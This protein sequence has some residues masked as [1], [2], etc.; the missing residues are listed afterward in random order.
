[1]RTRLLLLAAALLALLG[2][3][4][5]LVLARHDEGGPGGGERAGSGPDGPA[6]REPGLATLPA[7]K[8]THPT[9]RGRNLPRVIPCYLLTAGELRRVLDAPMA[10]LGQRAAGSSGFGLTG[11]QREDCHWFS[12]L[13]DGPYVVLSTVTTTQLR[14]RGE[15]LTARKY[16]DTV[17]DG[18]RTYLR[19]IGDA[20][21]AYGP[22]SVAVLVGDVYLDVT[23]VT[24]DGHP[25]RDARRLAALMAHLRV[26][27]P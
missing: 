13:P 25:L 17:H 12:T 5:G 10:G 26:H 27:S 11:L 3:G 2:T 9:G 4:V 15:D 6:P 22:A 19:G 23:V 7:P 21:Y 1:M 14:D 16:F 18:P 24:D 20:A 8:A